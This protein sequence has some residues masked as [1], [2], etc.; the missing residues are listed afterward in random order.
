[1]NSKKII[2]IVSI[3]AVV[4]I[5][6]LTILLVALTGKK[7]NSKNTVAVDNSVSTE[8]DDDENTSKDD[9]DDD[10]DENE[11]NTNTSNRKK[12]ID[13]E[14]DEMLKALEETERAV[15]NSKFARYKGRQVGKNIS[16]LLLTLKS[17]FKSQEDTD[18][19]DE[20]LPYIIYINSDGQYFEETTDAETIEEDIGNLEENHSYYVEIAENDET[21][22]V[23]GIVI[24]YDMNDDI[25]EAVENL[26]KDIANK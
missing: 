15:F 6:L 11:T 5:L 22:F 16:M 4:I 21:G 13:E 23:H 17:N 7:D 9:E 20:H 19:A 25:K 2:I 1:M 14:D 24:S 18:Y 3:V 12:S 26:A 8:K 10:D